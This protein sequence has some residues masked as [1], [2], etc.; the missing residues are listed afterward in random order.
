M[1]NDC[2]KEAKEY[3]CLKCGSKYIEGEECKSCKEKEEQNKTEQ[4]LDNLE[5]EQRHERT[6]LYKIIG[7][8][9]MIF[10]VIVGLVLGSEYQK[11]VITYKSSVDSIYDRYEEQFNTE[12]MFMCWSA[13]GSFYIFFQ[14]VNSI[15]YRL[16]LLIDKEIE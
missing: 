10:M 11:K 15:C 14:I 4:C 6:K 7:K 9:V 8:V 12:L 2:K 1:E 16:D 3:T 13:G 5:K